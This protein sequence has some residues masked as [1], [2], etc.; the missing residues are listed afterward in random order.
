MKECKANA[1]LIES[2]GGDNARVMTMRLLVDESGL[3]DRERM[4]V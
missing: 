2:K 4:R 3:Y 1:A